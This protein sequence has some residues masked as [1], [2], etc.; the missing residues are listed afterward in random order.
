MMGD[1]FEVGA[2]V[3][4]SSG[5]VIGETVGSAVIDGIVQVGSG[6]GA[7]KS[8]QLEARETSSRH[9]HSVGVLDRSLN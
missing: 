1:G 3:V 6:V 8:R 7:D 9:V 4:G 5:I 2:R